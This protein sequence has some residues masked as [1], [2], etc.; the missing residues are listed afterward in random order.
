[1]FTMLLTLSVLARFG[2]ASARYSF[3]SIG[4]WGGAAL[5]DQEKTNV[6]AVSNAMAAVASQ[7][8]PAFII[9]T[10]DSFYWCGIQN[11]SDYQIKVDFEDPYS[12]PSLVSLDWYGVL[13]NHEYGYNVDAVLDYAKINKRWIM[14]SRYYT[15]RILV[16]SASKTYLSLIMLD[17]SPCIAGYR[18]QN[19]SNWDP[20]SSQYPTCSLDDTNDDFEGPCKFHENIVSQSCEAEFAW[21]KQ[22]LEAV[23]TNDWLI[24]VG[25][26][27][28]DEVNVADFTSALQSRGFSAYFGGHAHVLSQ[29]LIDGKG[30]YVTSGAGSLVNTADQ[31]QDRTAKKVMGLDIPAEIDI[32]GSNR[33]GPPGIG[34]N[35]SYATVFNQKVAG[36]TRSSFDELFTVLTTDY[37]SYTG[38]VIHSFSVDKSGKFV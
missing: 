18:Q 34:Q 4:D 7:S 16:D 36:F 38:E 30:A 9:Q 21:F 23:P 1:M 20:C 31:Q 12:Q 29:Y 5:G 24:V 11:T 22:Q 33:D 8:P 13:G 25:H 27:P 35:H 17:T 14:D 2:T 28:I 19:P 15:K 32:L 3:L 6:Y 10:G 37:I 26:H